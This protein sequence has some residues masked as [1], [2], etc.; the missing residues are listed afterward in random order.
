MEH[1]ATLKAKPSGPAISVFLVIAQ[2]YTI[3]IDHGNRISHFLL[4][5]A[6]ESEI[7][8]VWVCKVIQ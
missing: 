8:Q 5:Y 1:L 4:L 3:I 2:N 6:W 7:S